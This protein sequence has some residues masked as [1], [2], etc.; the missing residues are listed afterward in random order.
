MPPRRLQDTTVQNSAMDTD[1]I[2]I[3]AALADI[4]DTELAAMIAAT[5]RVPQP[6]PGLL[7]WIDSAC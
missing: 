1:L 2:A 6:A 7:V 4:T 5:C 3:K